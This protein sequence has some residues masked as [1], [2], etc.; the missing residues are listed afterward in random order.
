MC[1]LSPIKMLYI[2]VQE[3]TKYIN[4]GISP[5]AN[6]MFRCKDSKSIFAHTM[7]LDELLGPIKN[8]ID[9]INFE[10]VG[11]VPPFLITKQNKTN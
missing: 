4:D 10:I 2:C 9:L 7:V 8:Q 1:N 5:G 3:S 11:L 6:V